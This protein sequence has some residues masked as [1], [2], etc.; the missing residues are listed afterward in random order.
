M[1]VSQG[2]C[3]VEINRPPQ[4]CTRCF[5]I[6]AVFQNQTERK[7]SRS[8]QRI[9][10]DQAIGHFRS[11]IPVS[12]IGKEPNVID[13]ERREW[14]GIRWDRRGNGGGKRFVYGYRRVKRRPWK[15]RRREI[16]V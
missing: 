16:V 1:I 14:L 7:L 8:I 5:L 2:K 9:A 3:A 10:A 11:E 13:I 4:G 12:T 6:A 15:C